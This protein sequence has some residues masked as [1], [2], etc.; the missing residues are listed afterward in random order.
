MCYNIKNSLKKENFIVKNYATEGFK[1]AHTVD[2]TPV[3]GDFKLHV[4]DDFELFC[5]VSG[6]VGYVV[7]GSEYELPSGSIMIMR[8]AEIHRLIV[9]GDERYE[10]YIINFSPELLLKYGFDKTVLDAYLLRDLGTNNQYLPTDFCGIEP[11]GFIRQLKEALRKNPSEAVAV[12]YLSALLYSVNT[13]FYKRN[14]TNES[15]KESFDNRLISYINEHL[16]DDISLTAISE[17]MHISPSQLNRIFNK[18]T[19]VSV[20]NYIISKRLVYAHGM[21]TRG[22]SATHASQ[23]CGFKDYSSFYRMYKKRFGISPVATKRKS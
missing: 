8:S 9:K 7:E 3:D 6:N 12:S 4:H 15:F 20:Y 19:G 13:A 22:E 17:T 23:A 10:R 18:L 2:D 11:L 21:I 16:L 5:V 1:F 14:D